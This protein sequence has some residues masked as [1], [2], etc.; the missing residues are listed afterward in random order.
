MSLS[1]I[2]LRNGTLQTPVFLPDATLGVVRSVDATDLEACGVEAV[3]MN[4]FHLMQRP[5]SSTIQSLGGVH[6]MSGWKGPI[7]TDSG[8]FQAYSLIRQN[9][10]NGQ[11]HDKGITFQPEGSNRKYLLTPE[12]TIQLQMSYGSDILVCLDDCTH[13]DENYAEQKTAVDRT[14]AWAKKCRREFD[15]LIEQ[16][17]FL[18]KEQDPNCSP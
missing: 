16:K 15:N 17:N 7:M 10:K 8:G 4:T 11:I 5:G 18:T 12:K 9:P 2:K 3:V 13:V 1:E 6:N 14:I